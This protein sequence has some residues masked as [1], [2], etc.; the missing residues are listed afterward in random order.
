VNIGIGVAIARSTGAA[1]SS[2]I[3]EMAD[4]TLRMPSCTG[5]VGKR[6]ANLTA[7]QRQGDDSGRR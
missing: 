1:L 3:G 2:G 5:E 4:S 7:D 6:K